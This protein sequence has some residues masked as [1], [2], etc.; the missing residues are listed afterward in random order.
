M[1]DLAEAEGTRLT[2]RPI[3]VACEGLGS[4]IVDIVREID[5]DSERL[6]LHPAR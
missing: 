6:S 1:G 3:L 2:T 5:C 4:Y